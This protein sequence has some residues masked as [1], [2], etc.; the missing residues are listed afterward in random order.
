M[1]R[2]DSRMTQRGKRTCDGKDGHERNSA[3]QMG[4]EVTVLSIELFLLALNFL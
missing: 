4:A 3:I 2:T 1:S